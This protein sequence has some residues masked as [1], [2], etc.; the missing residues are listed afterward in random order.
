MRAIGARKRPWDLAALSRAKPGLEGFDPTGTVQIHLRTQIR[1]VHDTRYH[2]IPSKIERRKV[3]PWM[4][5]IQ[6]LH[7]PKT[8]FSC[9]HKKTCCMLPSV[10]S[11][12]YIK[13]K[14]SSCLRTISL[15]MTAILVAGVELLRFVAVLSGC[16]FFCCNQAAKIL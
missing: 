5:I 2:Q 3:D 12:M 10:S 8:D 16:C 1:R 11:S 9:I 7:M 15:H 6:E 14:P 4:G 13:E